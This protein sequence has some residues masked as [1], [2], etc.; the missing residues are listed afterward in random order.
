VAA[1]VKSV[2]KGARALVLRRS[3][4]DSDVARL[5]Q[6]GFR[7]LRFPEP[8]E[9]EYRQQ[10]RA[11]MQ[12]WARLSI[13]VSALTVIGF[14]IIDHF[15][16]G[17]Q[18]SAVANTVRFTVHIPAV[19]I[20][21]LFTW[22][23]LYQRGYDPM[24]QIVAPVFGLGTVIMAASAANDQIALI[25]ARL[26]LATFFFY[27]MLG[28]RFWVA[29]RSNVVVLLGL[30]ACVA[31]GWM[32][33]QISVYVLFS[34]AC[35]NLIGGAGLYALEQANRLA[36]L[37]RKMLE[38]V[39][40]H[41][42]LTGLL[43]RAAF[44]DQIR[45]VWSQA[46]RDRQSVA[47]IMIDID[48]FK[49]F[50]DR[51]G[52]QAGDECLRRVAGAVASA[53][54]RR[55]LDFVARYGGEELVAVLYGADRAYGESVAR[56]LIAAVSELEIAHAGSLAQPYVTISIGLASVEAYRTPSHDLV[57]NWADQALYAAKD[58]GRNRFVALDPVQPRESSGLVGVPSLKT[59]S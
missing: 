49:A 44:E 50:N 24:I 27:F 39:A 30:A 19:V 32:P 8:L 36:F 7:G 51:Y 11:K 54:N 2:A 10:H 16:L 37:E 15:V 25:G 34:L 53:A 45:S 4:S 23:R 59:G 13:I 41:D 40:T 33:L 56:A 9:S 31:F 1:L 3:S 28:L 29:L 52:H 17:V 18:G 26:M 46:Q 6:G 48:Y 21:L 14:A 5:L 38:E 20:M 35:A 57:V 43:N 47:V 22:T 58:Q 42:G 12:N 55:P